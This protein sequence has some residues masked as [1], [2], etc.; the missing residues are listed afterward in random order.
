MKLTYLFYAILVV[1]ALGGG[2]Y[3]Y[4][5]KVEVQ[6]PQPTPPQTTGQ[7]QFRDPVGNLETA[8]HPK[9]P[10]PGSSSANTSK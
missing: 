4:V 5:T 10:Q 2:A 3:Y 1:A 8:R 7:P 9:F 6:A